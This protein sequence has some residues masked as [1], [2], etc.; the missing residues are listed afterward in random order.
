MEEGKRL[1]RMLAGLTALLCLAVG[2]CGAL[3]LREAE[4][5]REIAMQQQREMADVIAAM[6]DIEVN[7]SKLLVASGA[8][9]SVS[10]LGETAIL[11]QHVESGLSRLTAG[12]RATGDAMKFAGQMGQYSLALAAQVSDGGMLTGEDERQIEDMMRACHALGEQLVGQGEAVSWPESETK[13]AVEYPALIYDGPFSDGKTEGSA[14]LRGSSRVTRRQAREA[15]AR[16][17]G[18]TSDRVA[19]AADSG[20]RFEAFGFTA[21]TPDGKIA[22]QVTGQ[23]GYLLWMMPENAAFA[24]R[25]DVRTCLQ[26]AKVYLADVGFG[27]MEPC[28]VQQ[29]DGMAVAN[30][31]AVQDGVTLYPDQVKVQ[32]SMDSGRVVGAECSQY[33]ANH[34]RRTDVTPTV[35]AARAREMVS[36]KLTIRSERL[37]VIPL[38][39]GEALCW[40]FSCTDGAADYWVFVN[41]K[42]GETE[43]LLRVIATEQGEA[44]M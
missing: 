10:L 37:C 32:V 15:A 23:G 14:A 19:D 33:L 30:F 8:R 28:F 42:S 16:Y 35:T 18:V 38:E 40:G 13:S 9:Q 22:V 39:A 17:A 24:R 7:L 43:Q 2:L 26:N 3:H 31:A 21:D 44:A 41:A 34:T 36:P 20:G 4:L 12:E 1:R 6:A 27:E 29:Y 11:A 5:R 25:Y